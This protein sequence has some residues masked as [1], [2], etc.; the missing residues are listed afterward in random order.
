MLLFITAQLGFAGVSGDEVSLLGRTKMPLQL[1][2]IKLG[3]G[4]TRNQ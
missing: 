4:E 3:K 1:A 2:E